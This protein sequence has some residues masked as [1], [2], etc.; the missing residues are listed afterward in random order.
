M[1][2]AGMSVTALA[3]SVRVKIECRMQGTEILS[4]TTN[5][6]KIMPLYNMVVKYVREQN[7]L[8]LEPDTY[9]GNLGAWQSPK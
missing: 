6:R 2:S 5:K 4:S 8:G 1:M 9:K 7:K 3:G